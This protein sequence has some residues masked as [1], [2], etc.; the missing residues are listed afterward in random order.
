M[1]TSL[2]INHVQELK[3]SNEK[4][5]IKYYRKFIHLSPTPKKKASLIHSGIT[6]N[7]SSSSN[8]KQQQ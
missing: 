3:A 7:N 6:S 4:K 5:T 1:K 2:S 8:E